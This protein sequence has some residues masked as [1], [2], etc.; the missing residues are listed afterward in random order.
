MGSLKR[1]MERKK[2]LKKT[3]QSKKQLKQALNATLGM[4][5]KCSGCSGDFDPHTDADTWMVTAYE[6]MIH[7]FCPSCYKEVQE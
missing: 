1:K 7:L 6:D 2:A 4:P 3:K 5:T